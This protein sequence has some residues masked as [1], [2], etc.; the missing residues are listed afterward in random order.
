MFSHLT[1]SRF[2][3]VHTFHTV[4]SF[5][6]DPL[7]QWEAGWDSGVNPASC[8]GET[9]K[10]I[11]VLLVDAL[12]EADHDNKGSMPVALLLAKE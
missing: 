12:D 9:R 7:T 10:P 2:L 5:L 6:L 4:C 1:L 3:Y 8:N 11:L